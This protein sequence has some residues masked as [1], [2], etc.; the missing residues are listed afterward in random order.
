[1]TGGRAHAL[2]RGLGE[3]PVWDGTLNE[4]FYLNLQ[5]QTGL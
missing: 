4:F 2:G 3:K 5:L 1:M